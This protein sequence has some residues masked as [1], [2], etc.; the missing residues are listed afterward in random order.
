MKLLDK[1]AYALVVQVVWNIHQ[2]AALVLQLH[3]L[4]ACELI[5]VAIERNDRNGFGS[6]DCSMVCVHK[7][8][9]GLRKIPVNTQELG[10]KNCE[11]RWSGDLIVRADWRLRFDVW[12]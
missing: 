6:G 7:V 3:A 9:L 2:A 4:D 12:M 8:H 1:Q 10:I 5:K 11:S